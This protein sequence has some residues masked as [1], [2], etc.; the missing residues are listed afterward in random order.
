MS[1]WDRVFWNTEATGTTDQ[2]WVIDENGNY[3]EVERD[4]NGNPVSR[5][6]H[7]PLV[8]GGY[9][10]EA[11]ANPDGVRDGNPYT[12][13]G[14]GGQ[15][16]DVGRYRSLG[17]AAAQ[18]K[19]Y[20]PD[21][22]RA[23]MD[24]ALWNQAHQSQVNAAGYLEQGA[25]GEAP[26]RAE[27][28][29][30]QLG[31]QSLEASMGAQANAKGGPLAQ[32]AAQAQ[33][34]QQAQ[35]LQS[36]GIAAYS[37]MRGEEMNRARGAFSGTMAGIRGQTYGQQGLQQEQVDS[38]AKSENFQRQLNQEAQMSYE[39]R[40]F[41]VNKSAMQAGL[42]R[43]AVE[44]QKKA[45]YDRDQEAQRNADFQKV[46][47]GIGA[48]GSVIAS[49]WSDE[50]SKEGVVPLSD[51]G[52]MQL[53]IGGDGR[54]FYEAPE[55]GRAAKK[56]P[57]GGASLSGPTPRYSIAE[58]A[59]QRGGK[60]ERKMSLAELAAWADRETAKT[61]DATDRISRSKPAVDPMA[62]ANRH[63]APHEWS[64]KPEFTPPDQRVG[65]RQVGPMAQDMAAHPLT[66]TMVY[67]EPTTG[68]LAINPRKA[69]TYTLGALGSLQRQLDRQD[70]ELKTMRD[71][72][73]G[74]PGGILSD[75][76]AK[77][78]AFVDGMNYGQQTR[79]ALDAG[80]A[81]P[82]TP[83]Y[84]DEKRR[85]P[86]PKQAAEWRPDGSS[87]FGLLESAAAAPGVLL[88]TGETYSGGHTVYGRELQDEPKALLMKPS[89]EPA[90]A[91]R[92]AL[93]SPERREGVSV[94]STVAAR[95]PGPSLFEAIDTPALLANVGV[96]AMPLAPP[97][98]MR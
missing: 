31:S 82:A 20:Q 90:M 49:V 65:E 98:R 12:R 40:A 77:R 10:S 62:D 38:R 43:E 42:A 73:A 92:K 76:R 91:S 48:A 19:A 64:Y 7:D 56:G 27:I 83:S 50:R 25:R 44:A 67:K 79:D 21:F 32:A 80:Q 33:A 36:Q 54:A 28:L 86:K 72:K 63:L 14:P 88:G 8:W 1:Q 6:Q 59:S 2:G 11:A 74:A 96:R 39:Q 5:K 93:R 71:G 9:K 13:T 58:A 75:A 29:G 23:N 52:E 4:A 97:R 66:S 30:R 89:G 94:P 57:T 46:A 85:A 16:A 17:E 87:T 26:S 24:T 68:L 53:R 22:G 45:A 61:K 95:N 37:G 70:A 69:A 78:E 3:V 18:R 60:R 35:S 81:V 34:A 15:E 84:L 55:S 47:A 41:D 51:A